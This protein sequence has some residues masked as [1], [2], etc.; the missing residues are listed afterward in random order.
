QA[1][2]RVRARDKVQH[3]LADRV[4]WRQLYRHCRVHPRAV[5]RVGRTLDER[6]DSRRRQGIEPGQRVR[7]VRPDLEGTLLLDAFTDPHGTL[8]GHMARANSQCRDFAGEA[9]VIFPGPHAYVSPTWSESPGTVPT[10]N[11][12]AVHAYGAFRLVEASDGLH[13]LLTRTVAVYQRR[14]PVPWC[15]DVADPTS[16][17]CS[18]PSSASESNSAAWRARRS[19]I[20][21][22]PKSVV[23]R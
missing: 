15:Y 22:T 12:V 5:V 8:L 4:G 13:D 7:G 17:R 6:G 14:M 21:T 10:W 9:L 18:R 23:G 3:D 16:T 1:N 20:R 19:P 11:Y 2:A